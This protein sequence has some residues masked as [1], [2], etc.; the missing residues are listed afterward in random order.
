MVEPAM[1][2]G[3]IDLGGTKIEVVILDDGERPVAQSRHPT[4]AA[5]GPPA[6]VEAIAGAVREAAA[7]VG[8]V[9]ALAGVGVGSPGVVDTEAGTVSSARNL[10][11]W[12]GTF[13]LGPKLSDA[14]GGLPVRV[15]N[16]V[17][18]ALEAEVALG[19][20]RTHPSFLGVWWGTGVGGSLVLDGRRL[21]GGELGHTVVRMGGARCGCGRRGCLEAYAGRGSME[22]RARQLA[23]RGAKT[24]LFRIARKRERERLTSGVWAKALEEGDELAARLIERAVRALAAG[25]ASIRNL[26]EYDAVVL[27]GGLGT[28]FADTAPQRIAEAMQAHLFVPERAPAVVSAELGDLGGAIGAARLLAP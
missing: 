13:P 22:R 5:G 19:A 18:V 12:E 20:G 11:D 3:G 21:P 4:P 26:I 14:L 16:D 9:E 24:E 15:G 25:A 7:A 8:G 28:R 27:G 6:I 23:D 2:R 10:S 1:P 17:A